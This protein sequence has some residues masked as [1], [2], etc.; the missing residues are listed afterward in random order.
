MWFC[1]APTIL[2]LK[3]A[4][5]ELKFSFFVQSME[6][7]HGFAVDTVDAAKDG[8]VCS[9]CGLIL[10]EAVQTPDGLRLCFQCFEAIKR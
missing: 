10:N 9:E 6:I 5:F 1:V 4:G 2:L 3:H 8:L 7:A